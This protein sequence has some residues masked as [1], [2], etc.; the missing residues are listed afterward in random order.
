MQS[1][2]KS[3]KTTITRLNGAQSD[4][5]KAENML[6]IAQIELNKAII[7]LRT[8]VEGD[9]QKPVYQPIQVPTT[10]ISLDKLLQKLNAKFK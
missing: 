1:L 6:V 10:A 2:Y 9:T 5:V 4:L 3:A 7:Q 8:A